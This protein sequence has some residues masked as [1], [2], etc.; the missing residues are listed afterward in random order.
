MQRLGSFGAL[1]VLYVLSVLSVARADVSTWSKSPLIQ[2]AAG[3]VAQALKE[4]GEDMRVF[5]G[6][7]DS[8]PGGAA[9][10]PPAV[11]EAFTVTRPGNTIVIAGHD[12]AGA[13]YGGL[14]VA[15]QI[16]V[17]GVGSVA[18][19]EAKPFLAFR[20]L[21]YNFPSVRDQEWFHSEDYWRSF[22]DLLARSRFNSIG[23][24]HPHP[25][26]ELINSEMHPEARVLTPAQAE[27]N[28]RTWRMIFR[29]AKERGVSTYLI[30]WNI[31]LPEPFAKAHKLKAEGEDAPVVRDYMRHCVAETLRTYPDLTGLGLC[32]GERMPSDDY[33]W[34]EEWIKDTFIAGIRDS[35]RVVPL[36][37]RYWWTSPDSIKRIIAA[38]YPGPLYVTVK[39]NG[40][41]MYTDTRPHFLDPDWIDFPDYREHL[42]RKPKG[43]V[44]GVVSH[45]EWI[46]KEPYPY[47]VVWHLRNDTIHTYRWGD[48]DFVK[49]V[50]RNCAQP[51]A[52]GF[53]MG[54]ERTQTGLD[55]ELT[56]EA[57]KHQTWKYHHERHWFSTLLWGRL[58][59]DPDVP[60]ERWIA[61]FEKRFGKAVG[62]DLFTAMQQASKII[63]LVS[64]FHFNYMNG[65]WAPEWCAGSWNTGFG[66][67]RNYR[68]GR[69]DFHDIIEFIFNHTIDDSLLDI[70]EFAEMRLG[71]TETPQDTLTPTE[72]TARLVRAAEGIGEAL[73]DT[74]KR[75]TRRGEAESMCQE[76]RAV[77]DLGQY[78]AQKIRGATALMM[79]L[80]SG[81]EAFR[82]DAEAGASIAHLYW[83]RL[84]ERADS[85]YRRAQQGSRSY[86]RLLPRIER[87]IEIAKTAGSA[88][89]ELK[90][91][92]V[93]KRAKDRPRY[94][95]NNPEL[96]K[97]I[98]EKLA[99]LVVPVNWLGRV[100]LSPKTADVL[101]LGREAMAFNR[102]PAEKKKLVLDAIEQGIAL[103]VFFQNFPEFDASWLPGKIGGSERDAKAF[104]W[105]KPDH[106]IARG[107]AP[108][109]LEGPAVLNDSLVG[110]DAAWTCLTDPPGGLC[111]RSHG[112]GT[113][114]FCQLDV[115]GR[116]RERAAQQLVR[117]ILRFAAGDRKAPRIVL[118]DATGS[119]TIQ[120][121]NRISTRFQWI[122]ELPLAR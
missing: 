44:K 98:E 59:Y 68:D 113:I 105:T 107:V 109:E 92:G 67:G 20:Q 66:R 106:P 94:D 29:M 76:F 61:L 102:L 64:R 70:P 47:K 38:D 57:K 110:Y 30:N 73:R 41:Q 53:L 45:L 3:E 122:D 87:D 89:E 12:E 32:A 11:P 77:A 84:A 27:R 115:L 104:A 49:G 65:D 26:S 95:L 119:S 9:K 63:P 39:F 62:K 42:D 18:E 78:Y 48:P 22:F 31:H 85:V 6:T 97:L 111:I 33:D 108:K 43:E 81:R 91:L 88:P 58:G 116:Y 46:P 15:E 2:F 51:W 54:E 60:D 79:L 118:L 114:V 69:D 103:V 17:G 96:R 24:W 112:K 40:E 8:F 28:V 86:G 120:M 50:V 16:A 14:E 7:F 100:E 82:R 83:R 37:H 117:N 19:R 55:E 10:K 4:R 80:A 74:G 101:V 34:R 13:M 56:D 5:L 1:S 21:K 99:P 36:L 52:V 25:F 71:R 35:G 90:K 121:L 75:G 93:L 23:F 72:V